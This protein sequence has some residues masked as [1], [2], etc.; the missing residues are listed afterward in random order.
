VPSIPI[1][2]VLTVILAAITLNLVLAVAILVGR[3]RGGPASRGLGAGRAV[4]AATP[5][6]GSGSGSRPG[7]PVFGTRTPGSHPA[8]VQTGLEVGATWDRWLAEEDP[9]I[10][11]YRRPATVVL[12]EVS[13]LDRLTERLGPGAADRLIPPVATTLRRFAR[14]SDRVARLDRTTFGVILTETGEVE[15]INYVERVRSAADMWL[16]SGAVAVRLSIGWAE[17][18]ASRGTERALELA[19]ERLNADRLREPATDLPRR[20]EPPAA[21]P[22]LG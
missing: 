13:G 22:A 12:I 10:R 6:S 18:N 21:E 1:E 7:V 17:A 19:E 20:G 5:G 2:T 9:R 8:D 3:R 4:R 15:A 14:A 11:R 16:A